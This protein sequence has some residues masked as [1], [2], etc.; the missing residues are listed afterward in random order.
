MAS[1][2][3]SRPFLS[4]LASRALGWQVGLFAA[5][6]LTSA[7]LAAL[8]D[9]AALP[10]RAP[11][12]A[13]TVGLILFYALLA[14]WGAFR[15]GTLL[16]LRG[17]PWPPQALAAVVASLTT[18][19][20]GRLGNRGG[21]LGR[22]GRRIE[23]LLRTA[24]GLDLGPDVPA[25]RTPAERLLLLQ[26]MRAVRA[27]LR[28]RR[29]GGRPSREAAPAPGAARPAAGDALQVEA[30]AALARTFRRYLAFRLGRAAAGLAVLFALPFLIR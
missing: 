17:A 20:Y 4:A 1:T 14:A 15:L 12:A 26:T 11:S 23:S 9:A 5:L 29:W 6:L 25:P 22:A 24:R 8:R 30:A 28:R 27:F 21:A 7:L 16:A 2:A 3:A 10:G 19:T 18:V 13:G